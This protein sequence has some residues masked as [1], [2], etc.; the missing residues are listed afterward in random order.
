MA[1][2]LY[3]VSCGFESH[4]Q[5]LGRCNS[6]GKKP[7]PTRKELQIQVLPPAFCTHRLVVNRIL[8]KAE[9]Q[10]RFLLGALTGT[11]S[12]GRAPDLGFGGRGIVALVPDKRQNNK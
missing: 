4:R 2:D 11:S 7:C 12:I 3:S 5:L 1:T 6:I 9:S 10:V 8:G